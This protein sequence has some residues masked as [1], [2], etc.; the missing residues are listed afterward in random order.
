MKILVTGGAGFIGSHLVRALL[1]AK[2]EVLVLDNLFSGKMENMPKGAKFIL[3]DITHAG[4]FEP[5]LQNVDVC[6]HLAAIASVEMSWRDPE[7]S[8]K[9]NSGGLVNLYDAIAKTGRNIPVVYASS[10]AIYGNNPNMPLSEEAVPMPLS[11]YGADKLACE[12]HSKKMAK[13]S[14]I[15]N[16]GLRF[17]NVYG[18][19]QDASS[20]YSGVISIFTSRIMEGKPITIYGDGEHKRDFVYVGDIVDSIICAI[21]HLISGE[22]EC[23]VF[24]ICTGGAITVNELAGII[25]GSLGKEVKIIHAAERA[26]N[27]R[28]S[29][30]DPEHAAIIL[31][32]TATT[33]F[34]DGVKAML[35]C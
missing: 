6:V 20:P 32:Y 3:G 30:G 18:P 7:G 22:I 33:K 24:N 8:H 10:A 28:F 29:V 15:S 9:V 21:N 5:L 23:G 13:N 27:I 31:G 1:A 16:I 26:G 25:A 34:Y 14:G 4:V 2:H 35:T 11:H 17:F 19:G 12:M